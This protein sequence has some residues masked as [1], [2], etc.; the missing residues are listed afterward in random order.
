KPFID[1]FVHVYL[2]DILIYSDTEEEHI[3]HV[4]AVLQKLCEAKLFAKPK[5][6]SFHC[7]SV[8][9]LGFIISPDG[10]SMDPDKVK[11]VADWPTPKRVKDIQSFLGF[12]NF[13]RRFIPDFAKI[14]RPLTRLTAKDVKWNWT[15]L[16]KNAFVTI[17][18]LF[19]SDRILA[20]FDPLLPCVIDTDASDFAIGATLS[21][22]HDGILRPVAFLSRQLT[23]AEA[24]Y[25]THDKELLAIVYA[26]EMW[27]HFLL[28]L[29]DPFLVRTDHCNLEFF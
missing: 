9:Y 29:P 11:A 24:N 3:E 23:S 22:N 19:S 26:T 2:D 1:K 8:D 21:Q 5:K 17:R 25:D 7:S 6:C 14:A 4:R 15:D 12:V 10:T 27:R 13:Y 28:H 16:T 20:L 18:N